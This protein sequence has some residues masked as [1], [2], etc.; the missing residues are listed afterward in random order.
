MVDVREQDADDL[1]P[2]LVQSFIPDGRSKALCLVLEVVRGRLHDPLHFFGEHFVPHVFSDQVHLVDEDEDLGV[3]REV[4]QRAQAVHV[5]LQ[6]DLE[7]L[8]GHVEDENEHADVLEDV[9]SLR[10]EILLHKSVLATT[11]PQR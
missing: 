6:V 1:R 8:R 3:L 4:G 2:G 10:L 5:V 9:V 11:I 7:L